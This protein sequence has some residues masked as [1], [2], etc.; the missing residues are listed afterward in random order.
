MKKKLLIT[1]LLSFIVF[2]TQAQWTAGGTQ[3]S[4][5]PDNHHRPFVSAAAKGSYYVVW[6]ATDT[7][8]STLS[9][10]KVCAYDSSGMVLPGWQVGGD[11]TTHDNGDYFGAQLLTSEDGGV[12]V[13]WYGYAQGS[14]RSHIYAQ[15]YS[16]TKTVLWNFGNPVQVSTGTSYVDEY[17]RIVSD[18]HRGFFVTW[19]RFDSTIGPSSADV[20]LQHIDSNGNVAAGWNANGTGVATTASVRE[21]YPKLAFTPDQSSVYVTYGQG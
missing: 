1:S 4:F 12:I 17:P 18:K 21:Y 10:I 16:R 13:A 3:I 15:K 8:A 20:Y 9:K 5:S 7:T 11:T 6:Q 14:N 2:T 19:T